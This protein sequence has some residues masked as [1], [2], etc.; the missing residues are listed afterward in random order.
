MV[1]T[2]K[3]VH[4]VRRAK[5]PLDQ[6]VS[7]KLAE[8]DQIKFEIASLTAEKSRIVRDINIPFYEAK[9]KADKVLADAQTQADAIVQAAAKVKEDANNYRAQ[10]NYI[11]QNELVVAKEA[12]KRIEAERFKFENEKLDFEGY[13]IATENL[14][15]IKKSELTA[16]EV[17]AE[18]SVL[19]ANEASTAAGTLQATLGRKEAD[20]NT[21]EEQL[22]ALQGV[23]AEQK[24]DQEH[25]QKEL[26]G[27]LAEVDKS[28]DAIHADL[29]LAE[30]L[31]RDIDRQ[32]EANKKVSADLQLKKAEQDNQK[33]MINSQ[34]LVL[35][36]QGKDIE[37][38]NKALDEKAQ[39]IAVRDREVTE[40][41]KT[42]QEIRKK[43][44][45]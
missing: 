30:K 24:R 29:V 7:T 16:Q 11:I 17:I 37:E 9:A 20:L 14:L 36:R 26:D 42:L 45:V 15:K 22:K 13:K 3:E 12:T 34:C 44:V 33:S 6:E 41:I 10:S 21:L 32:M 25:R 23:L 5:M 18:R 39:L 27:L 8:L 28:K 4:D 38:R 40:K 35:E 31:K 2:P 19:A 43:N 1:V